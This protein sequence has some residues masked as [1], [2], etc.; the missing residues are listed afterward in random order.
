MQAMAC[1]SAGWGSWKEIM[2]SILYVEIFFIFKQR[3]GKGKGYF[4]MTTPDIIIVEN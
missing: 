2:M 1:K 4:L 3:F